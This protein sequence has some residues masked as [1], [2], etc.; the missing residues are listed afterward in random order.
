[1]PIT[2]TPISNGKRWTGYDWSIDSDHEL[3]KLVARIALG[4]YRHVLHILDQTDFVGS[5]P[6]NTVLKGARQLL[7]V[8]D[9]GEPFHRDG[10]LFQTISWIA[11]HIHDNASLIAPPHMQHAHKG[12]DSLH[13][14][15]DEETQIVRSVVICEDKATSNPRDTIR[16]LVWEEFSDLEAGNRDNLLA[17]EVSTLLSTRPELDPDQAIQ[18]VLWKKVRAFR[19]AI[20]VGD[21]HNSVNGRK[22]LFKGYSDVIS[23]Q[24]SRRRAETLHLNDLRLWMKRLAKK[25]LKTAEKMVASDV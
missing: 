13:V 9:G 1:M 2:L 14:E 24:V 11:A 25:A 7:T 21:G 18:Q 8:P 22:R 12:F 3:A 10:W 20:T 17:A 6:A 19:V 23:G 5:A 16:D 4:Q 15:I